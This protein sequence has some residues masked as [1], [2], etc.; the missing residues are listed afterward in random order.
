[1]ATG[2]GAKTALALRHVHFEDL[3]TLAPILDAAG[4]RVRYANA[5][6]PGFP[7]GDPL[8]PDLVVVLGGPIG[9]RQ[10]EAYPFLVAETDFIARRLAGD[11][12]TLGI[13]LGAQLIAAALG[14]S[15][16]PSDA[17]EIGFARLSLTAAGLRSPLRHL[18]DAHV[19][20]WHGDTYDLPQGAAHLAAT[21]GN[22]QQAFAWQRSLA[23]QFHLETDTASGFERWLI[24]HAH[25]LA[26]A[27]VDVPA[28]RAEAR[29][30]GK[31]LATAAHRVLG[32]WLSTVAA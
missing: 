5:W 15:V 30:R 23:L 27:G 22:P 3:G 29:R 21:A 12:P 8:A 25:E 11:L 32:E 19:L 24:G 2:T 18:E 28:L 31:A 17:P 26:A 4:Y 13:C 14:A 1:M 9:A 20:H 6:D 16:H 10:H 7:D